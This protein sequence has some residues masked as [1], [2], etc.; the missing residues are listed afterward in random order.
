MVMVLVTQI[1][2]IENLVKIRQAGA[3]ELVILKVKVKFKVKVNMKVKVKVKVKVMVMVLGTQK[4][5]PE[6]LVKIR[7][8]EA[9]E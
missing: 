8:G 7:Q 3:L 9:S 1:S 4:R 2:S 6:N 5:F